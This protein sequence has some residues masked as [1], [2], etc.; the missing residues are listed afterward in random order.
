MRKLI[1]LVLVSALALAAQS[2][3][4]P[5]VSS[6]FPPRSLPA[7]TAIVLEDAQ[8]KAVWQTGQGTLPTPQELEQAAYVAFSLPKGQ[9][10]RYA[11]VGKPMAK[12]ASKLEDLRVRIGKNTYTLGT[13]LENR[14]LAI[15]KDG[16]LVRVA[17]A[18][19]P[20]NR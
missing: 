5:K 19:T 2:G 20:A 4:G 1:G 6:V 11:V 8:G 9:V 13:L 10:Y 3:S 14:H 15:G 7:G 12:A 17:R 18:H 16:S